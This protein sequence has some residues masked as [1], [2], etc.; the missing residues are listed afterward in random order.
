MI[1]LQ[2]RLQQHRIM[3]GDE[4]FKQFQTFGE[5]LFRVE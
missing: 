5:E 1:D 2:D 4:C 3:L